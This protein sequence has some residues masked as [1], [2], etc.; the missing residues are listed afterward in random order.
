MT[1]DEVIKTFAP[2]QSTVDSIRAWLIQS[3]ISSERITHSDN[4]GWFAF[5]AT[6]EEASNLLHTEYHIFEHT[7]TG[8]VIPACDR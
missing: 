3:G 4:K 5:D 8:Q 6:A 7:E 2:L 1:A